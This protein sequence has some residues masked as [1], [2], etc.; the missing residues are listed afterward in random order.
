MLMNLNT[1]S[2]TTFPSIKMVSKVGAGAQS[3]QVAV[4]NGTK[5]LT[6]FDCTAPAPNPCR[7]GDYAAVT[8]DPSTAN[9][10]WNVSQWGNGSASSTF[11]TSKTQNFVAK[12]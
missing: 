8:P 2:S 9:L 3:G 11:A 1:S 5:P 10:M 6:G 7:W 4:F 12:P